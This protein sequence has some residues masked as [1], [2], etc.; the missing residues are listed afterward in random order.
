MP[1]KRCRT[2]IIFPGTVAFRRED[3]LFPMYKDSKVPL[4]RPSLQQNEEW[5]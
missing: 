1:R 4:H 5:I 3:K 2:E